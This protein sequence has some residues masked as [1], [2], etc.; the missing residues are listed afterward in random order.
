MIKAWLE[1][2]KEWLQVKVARLESS[3]VL[4]GT[5]KEHDEQHY[6]RLGWIVVLVGFGG[7]MLWATFAP[8]DQG[9]SAQGTV[10]SDG[11]AKVVQP[12]MGGRIEAILVKDGDKVQEGQIL[13]RLN[14]IQVT[15]QF[16]VA[17]EEISGLQQ[18][19]MALESSKQSK[20]TQLRTINEQLKNN[21]ELAKE[22]YIPKSKVL[23]I[24]RMQAQI[25]G[26]IY[27]DQGQLEYLR[28]QLNQTKEKYES[29]EYDLSNAEIKAP[30][31]GTVI[32][33]AQLTVGAVISPGT[34]LM[35]VVPDN[36]S[37]LIEAMLPIHLVDNV[38]PGLPVEMLFPAFDQI[39]APKIPGILQSI[40]A[41]RLTDER[42]GPYYKA[43][44]EVSPEGMRLLGNNKIRPGMPVEV[45]IIT[46][47][48]TMMSYLLKPLLD[49]S[50]SA[51]RER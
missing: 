42:L 20:E 6:A 27:D 22:G 28:R 24:E 47:E 1:M 33:L 50:R 13:A 49:R 10:M 35:S 5:H 19:I 31:A 30:A 4:A 48:R 34:K 43:K 45:F 3:R 9:V 41:D 7:F 18:K 29:F 38:Y 51:L 2:F 39:K 17:K 36:E 14:D 16:N 32:N 15:A 11:Y 12:V 8:L 46:G 44:V 37:L 25:T 26:A 21:R 23:D 40:S